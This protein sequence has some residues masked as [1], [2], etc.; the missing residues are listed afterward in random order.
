MVD[1]VAEV[2]NTWSSH[3]VLED[4]D[5]CHGRGEIKVYPFLFEAGSGYVLVYDVSLRAAQ[6]KLRELSPHKDFTIT[7]KTIL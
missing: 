2:K 5:Y 7:P 3:P 1:I 4:C 6:D